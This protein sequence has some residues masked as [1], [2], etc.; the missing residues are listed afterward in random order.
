MSTILSKDGTVIAFDRSGEGPPVILVHPA[1]GH[2]SFNP[3]M[4]ELARLLGPQF[5][6]FNYD[7]RGRGESGDTQPYAVEREVEDLGA[8]VAEAGGSAHVYGM[9]SGAALALEAANRG[10]AITKLALYEPPFVV[11]DTR[12]PMP[13]DYLARLTELASSG[14]RGDM[15]EYFMTAGAGVPAEVVA[16][17]RTQPVWPAFEAVAH[18]LVYDGTVMGDTGRGR[19]LPAERIASVTAPTLVIVGSGSPAW[20]RNSV[21]AL[22]DALPDG[23]MRTLEGEYHAV[24]AATLAPALAEFFA[25]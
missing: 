1:F 20:A 2:R 16:E 12:P 6:V 18:T 9:S 3:E 24:A 11:D 14:R 17:M 5:T 25:G 15:V 8:L 23:R 13:A 7:R 22:A 19:P 10:L 4:A 21:R